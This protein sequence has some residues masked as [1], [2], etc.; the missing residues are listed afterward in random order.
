MGGGI[1]APIVKKPLQSSSTEEGGRLSTAQQHRISELLWKSLI[2]GQS[3][4]CPPGMAINGNKSVCDGQGHTGM[5]RAHSH[6]GTALQLLPKSS[7]LPNEIRSWLCSPRVAPSNE[8][9]QFLSNICRQGAKVCSGWCHEAEP[10]LC[11]PTT[12]LC[13]QNPPWKSILSSSACCSPQQ[14]LPAPSPASR[15]SNTNYVRCN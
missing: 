14:T 2:S 6:W 10:R 12:Q 5:L 7:F 8:K 11:S 13:V 4:C 9:L 3:C 1:W 15:A